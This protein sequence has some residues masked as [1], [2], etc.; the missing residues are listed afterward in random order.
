MTPSPH[1]RAST[2]SLE[3]FAAEIDEIAAQHQTTRAEI[4]RDLI[5][6]LEE[7]IDEDAAVL[8][9]A[10]RL[11]AADRKP[12]DAAFDAAIDIVARGGAQRPWRGK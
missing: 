6:G 7:R 9:L 1:D 3:A 12:A 10:R 5:E 11:E 8:T 2:R 4:L